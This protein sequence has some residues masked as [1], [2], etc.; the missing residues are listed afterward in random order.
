MASAESLGAPRAVTPPRRHGRRSS[1]RDWRLRDQLMYLLAWTV[2]LGLC[3]VAAT[4]VV[5]YAVEGI[6][7]LHPSLLFTHPSAA[8]NQTQSGGFLDP[9]EGTIILGALG[10]A[11]AA[12]IGVCA[13]VWDVE[14][15]RPRALARIVES[16]IEIVA[17][18]PDIVIAIFGLALFQLGAFA[19]FSFGEPGGAYGRS[20]LAAGAMM[21]LVALPSVY[22]ATR[23]GLISTPRQ[24]REASYALGKT[25]I[26]TIRR[27]V[28]PA[29]RRDIAT[30][31]T[32]GLG[33]IIG[34]TAIVLVLLGGTLRIQT[35][36]SLP[37]IG[38][39]RGTGSTLTSLIYDYSP[40]GDGNQP[41]KAYAA[42]FIL[43]AIVLA[44]NWAVGR[45][46]R[47]GGPPLHEE[48]RLGA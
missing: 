42:A 46:A 37:G 24:L 25:R 43:L 32:L 36:G 16:S 18:T 31:S 10:I 8:V 45:I 15:G 9:I 17:G 12:P 22:T 33:R 14:Y 3:L 30:G 39:L 27:V 2:G 11:I 4:F 19:P 34:D 47:I 41:Q 35:E 23:S 21:S 40:S 13:A 29:V 38:L 5:F 20:F 44:L 6:R 1:L 26:A 48:R 7:Y 28:L